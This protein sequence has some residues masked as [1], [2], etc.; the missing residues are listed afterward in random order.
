MGDG[1]KKMKKIGKILTVI[2][3]LAIATTCLSNS[4]TWSAKAYN[5]NVNTECANVPLNVVSS[6]DVWIKDCASDDGTEPSD[7]AF[8]WW[9]ASPDIYYDNNDDGVIDD[10]VYD[11]E[12][13]L[14]ANVRNRGDSIVYDVFVHFYY[15]Q[16][17]LGLVFPSDNSILIGTVTI[18]QIIKGGV[19]TAM[20]KWTIPTPPANS[21]W[22]I[23][24]VVET[25]PGDPQT[26]TSP[27][28][29]NNL[30]CCNEM[31]IYA[32]PDI[33]AWGEF[34]ASN[35][36][37]TGSEF[38]M[39]LE[40]EAPGDW[41]CDTNPTPGTV[42]FLGPHETLPVQLVV[43]PSEYAAHGDIGKYVVSQVTHR[44]EV[45]GGIIFTVIINDLP[46]KPE[47]PN[48][49]TEGKI[50]TEYT[51]TSSA[52]DPDGDQVKYYFNW[53]DETC[54]LTDFVNSGEAASAS[55]SW[56]QEGTYSIKVKAVDEYGAASEW[57][58]PLSVTMPRGR[59]LPDTFFMRL[60]ERF[61]NAFPLIRHILG[62]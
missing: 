38:T 47:T 12:N 55:H 1:G 40:A 23:G 27:P 28:N 4:A 26:S 60:L 50:G 58:D 20:T 62:L 25:T 19:K 51:Y 39:N 54:S 22:C 48:G 37:D 59:L 10:Y 45:I 41:S 8:G 15:T 5:Q 29:D 3:C 46:N 9:W 53:G 56:S 34:L 30:A 49:S 52:I 32:R 16:A 42:F 43:T 17:N 24:V 13:H 33:D 7:C 6:E 18:L 21:H 35:P 31:Y 2:I 36:F 14:Y 44:G 11:M 57:S 61:P